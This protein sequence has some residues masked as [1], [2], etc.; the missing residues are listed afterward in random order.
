MTREKT[1][2]AGQLSRRV[3]SL[4]DLF[5]PLKLD[6]FL[7]TF[8]PHVRYL[9]GF[10]GSNGFGLVTPRFATLVT[11]GR[12]DQQARKEA[13]GWRVMIARENLME[14]MGKQ[15]L[16]KPG[17]R[18]GFDGNTVAF[19]QFREWK[20]YFPRVKFLPRVDT[21]EWLAAVKDAGEISSLRS[22]VEITDRVFSEILHLLKPGVA[23]SDIAA[24]IS[25]RQRKLGAD[26]DAFE[27]IVA[28]G[29][30]SAMPHGKAGLKK[31]A[32][33]DAVTLDFGCVV[34]GYH[35]DLTRTVFLGRCSGELRNIYQIVR[36]AQERAIDFAQAGRTARDLDA[37]ARSVITGKGYGQFFRHSLGHG[38]GLQIHE[39][40]RISVLSKAVLTA[41]NVVT[42]EPGIYLPGVG[43]VR[44]EDD[45]VITQ[46]GCEVLN[47]A[48]KELMVL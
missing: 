27:A 36:D 8:P 43:G 1:I 13:D 38:I 14:E 45:I 4:R 30:R 16:L 32:R 47:S 48:P 23:E 5:G 41:G 33:G 24:E 10:T 2:H 17:M 25:Y 31:L 42:I 11:D 12:Y 9:S 19:A 20:K 29:A 46:N 44:I 15:H 37:A 26:G 3:R 34:R 39:S 22:A 7:A 40:P 18:V 21:V 6:A 28:S 35:S